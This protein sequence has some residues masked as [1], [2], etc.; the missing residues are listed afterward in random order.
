MDALQKIKK[1][2]EMTLVG[3]A[4]CKEA[5]HKAA[6]DFEKALAL[7]RE[8]GARISLKKAER[9]AR[10]GRIEAY[11]HFSGNMGALVEV[12][13]ETDFVART[14]VFKEFTKN[15]AMHIAAVSPLY[16][17]PEDIPGDAFNGLSP[18]EKSAF[19]KERCL[20]EQPFVKD[21]AKTIGDYLN[22][23]VSKVGE[24]VVIKRFQRFA[25]GE[26]EET[27]SV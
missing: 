12:N 26:H 5:L 18:E 21:T 22:E 23:T 14:D 9:A 19:I 6:G 11:V 15:I 27:A 20:M 16:V 25:L 2:R 10:Q 1:L 8:R 13:C 4:E 7:L 3:I 24:R 17:K